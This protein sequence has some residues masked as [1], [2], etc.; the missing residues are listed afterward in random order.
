VRPVALGGA[1]ADVKSP[2]ISVYLPTRDRA[3][4]V[5]DAVRS[6]LAQDYPNIELIVVD[7]GSS[8]ETPGILCGLAAAD[9]RMRVL[10][11]GGGQG[12][13][14]ARNR[15]ITAARG[16]FVTGLDDDDRML[17][18]RVRGLLDAYRSEYAFVCSRWYLEQQGTRRIVGARP[19]PITLDDLLHANVVGNQVLAPIEYVRSVGMFD[20]SLPASEDHDLWTRL[21]LRYGPGLGIRS[22]TLIVRGDD[23]RH[24]L[25]ASVAASRGARL[26]LERY[27]AY[28]S[29]SHRRSQR[30]LLAITDRRRLRLGEAMRCVTPM[31]VG[32]VLGYAVR[33]NLPRLAGW[34]DR[35]RRSAA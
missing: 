32:A 16:V 34:L 13:A 31:N 21:V 12:P 2:L 24:R 8:D 4:L 27:A 33:S 1:G 7:D 22:P 23:S 17:P 15:A 19:G 18:G 30:L 5:A 35:I 10:A 29:R 14:I 6:V 3:R 25:S 26:Y 28:M 11:T 9:G 20:P